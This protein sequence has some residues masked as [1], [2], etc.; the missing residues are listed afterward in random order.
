MNRRD[1]VLAGS[2]YTYQL[3][4]R[5]FD[6]PDDRIQIFYENGI[7]EGVFTPAPPDFKQH[8]LRLLFVG[9]L[10]PYKCADVV[11]EA[12]SCLPVRIYDRRFT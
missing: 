7:A 5:L 10:V 4:K 6:I 12:I 1:R 2:T 11:V 3:L 9:R 8:M